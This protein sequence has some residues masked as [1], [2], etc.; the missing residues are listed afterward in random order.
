LSAKRALLAAL[1]SL[2]ALALLALVVPFDAPELG[3]EVERRVRSA[4][5]IPLAVSSSRFRLLQGLVLEESSASGNFVSGSYRVHLPRIVLEHRPLALLRGRLEL[6]RIRLERPTAHLY[7]G[8]RSGGRVRVRNAAVLETVEASEP[9]LEVDTDLDEI[10]I[11]EGELVVPERVSIRG[12]ALTLANLDYDRRA[13]TPLHALRSQ[14]S[15]AVKEIVV[16]SARL[17]DVAAGIATEGGR[18]QLDALTLG[19]DRGELSGDLM[20]DFNSFPFR[21]RASLLGPSF[22]VEGIGR[23]TLRLDA[24]GF[25]TRARDLKGKGAFDLE[26]GRLPDVPWVREIDP[27][28]A[29]AEHAPVEIAFEVRDER[30]YFERFELEAKGKVLELEGSVGLDGSR[31]IRGSVRNITSP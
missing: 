24:E 1:A 6:T 11:E 5:G 26:R 13:L 25:G 27:T 9:W 3:R 16:E 18:L 15:V 14:G 31:D 7:L 22:E 19:S 20:L 23:G 21:Y 17:R 8:L 2:A 30:V 28:L 12:L 10:R 29:G 4:T